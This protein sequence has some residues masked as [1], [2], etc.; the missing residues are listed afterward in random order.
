MPVEP[1]DFT[2]AELKEALRKKGLSMSGTK[3]ELIQRLTMADPAIWAALA[4]TRANKERAEQ[5]RLAEEMERQRLAEETNRQ[6]L[7]EEAEQQRLAEE[8]EQQRLAEEAEQR[9]VA[10]QTERQRLTEEAERERLAHENLERQRDAEFE[11]EM[12][13]N[14][15]RL[16]NL[17]CGMPEQLREIELLR[18]E[19]D[20]MRREIELLQRERLIDGTAINTVSNSPMSSTRLGTSLTTTISIRS[21][22]E[23]L[24][25]FDA[26]DNTFWLWKQQL[27][28]LRDTYKLDENTT[29]VLISTKLKGRALTWFHSKSEHLTSSVSELLKEMSTMFDHRPGKLAQRREFESRKWQSNE[30][31][32]DYYHD[33]VILANRVPIAEDE[34]VDYIIDGIPDERLQDQARIQRF[35]EKSAL[36]KAFEKISVSPKKNEPRAREHSK[37][38][39]PYVRKDKESVTCYNCSEKGHFSSECRKPRKPDGPC[40]KCGSNEH[41]LADCPKQRPRTPDMK[42][43]TSSTAVA[44]LTSTQQL[45]L[46][47]APY[48]VAI[49]YA[50]AD[51]SGNVCTYSVDAMIDSGSPIS[52]IKNS[53]VPSHVKSFIPVQESSFCGING[54]RLNVVGKFTR[55]V[56]IEG[57]ESKVTFYVVPD[58]TMA[59]MAILGRDFL[60]NPSLK[61]TMSDKLK[62]EKIGNVQT[63]SIE[64]AINEIMNID[65]VEEPF[66]ID[67][68][69]NINPE[70]GDEKMKLIKKLYDFDYI[71]KKESCTEKLNFEMEIILKHEQPIS[72][73]LRRLAFSEK[74]KLRVIIDDLLERG[75]IR[76]SNSPYASPI[77]LRPKKSGESRLVIDYREL[78]KITIKDNYP[79]QLID[80]N[81]DQLRGKFFLRRSI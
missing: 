61:I 81:L 47:V 46:L 60:S 57:I 75:L 63:E 37:R 7:A 79:C 56:E 33:K 49:K 68:H 42:T 23:L 34:M 59:F 51:E 44:Q 69:L 64:S 2:V 55:D 76:P 24:N 74:E 27:I 48:A 43:Q 78:N 77:L 3:A 50:I 36:L 66:K 71:K 52:L 35:E 70:I 65:Y 13:Q 45:A 10:E 16:A 25:N 17:R 11:R 15:Q 19:R 31:F 67:K 6:R 62:I 58:D 72:F 9:R 53:Y 20:L 14:A 1:T 80:D 12:A 18:R 8:A 21:I 32:A 40:F 22:G 29:K 39:D 73:R 26:K 38:N 30:P 5:Q 41:K 54:S 28:L 4:E